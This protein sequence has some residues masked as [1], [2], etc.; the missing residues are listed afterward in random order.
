MSKSNIKSLKGCEQLPKLQCLYLY[1]NDE[2][3]DISFLKN[4]KN[5]LKALRICNCNQ[6][7]DF[8]V[9]EEL[10]NLELLELTGTNNIPSL[11][12]IKKLKQLRTFFFSVNVL[13]NDLT[14][15]F[16]LEHVDCNKRKLSYNHRFKSLPK[17]G[18]VNGASSDKYVRGNEDIEMWRRFE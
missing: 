17:V 13:D 11:S 2:L 10:E 8:S 4:V 3:S 6:I 7:E 5:T 16:D 1:D 14:P 18:Y 12:F 15:C 9:L